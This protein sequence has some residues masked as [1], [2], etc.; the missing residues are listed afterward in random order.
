MNAR[1]PPGNGK[2]SGVRRVPASRRGRFAPSPTGS[3]H[4]GNARTALAAWLRARAAGDSFIMRVED[5][6][7]PRTVPAAVAGNLAEL[8]WLGLDWDEGPDVGG[9]VGPYVQSQR[10]GRYERA[11]EYLVAAGLTFEC[12]LSRKDLRELASAP[13]EAA[14]VYGRRERLVNERSATA[15]RAEGKAPSIR[16]KGPEAAGRRWVEFEDL[17]AGPRRYEVESAVG[18]IVLHRADGVWAYQLAV[19]VD[20]IAMGVREVVRG[21][22]LLQSTAA[23]LVLYRALE[24]PPPRFLHVPLLLDADGERMAKRRS[25]LTLAALREAGVP[26]ERVTG[27]LGHSLGLLPAPEPITPHELLADLPPDWPEGAEV[28]PF[29]LG[30]HPTAWLHGGRDGSAT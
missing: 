8:R 6:D 29:S 30:E 18:D 26:P 16:L 3:L 4:L 19:V 12:Y 17:L 11:L 27:L 13:H 28:E 24:A 22:D 2:G 9:P 1:R 7:G 25:S 23:Q 5:L 20:D 21:A 14:P 15:R 10:V